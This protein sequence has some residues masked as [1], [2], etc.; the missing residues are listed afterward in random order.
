MAL[1][2]AKGGVRQGLTARPSTLMGDAGTK[3]QTT[4]SKYQNQ[5]FRVFNLGALL[6]AP[7]AFGISLG[8]GHWRL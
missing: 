2:W 4:N 6:I 5:E 8:F 7:M 1:F 3:S